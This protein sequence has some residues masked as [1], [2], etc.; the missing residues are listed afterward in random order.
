MSE[1]IGWILI[2][3]CVITIISIGI[4]FAPED[5]SEMPQ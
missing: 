5:N 1:T 4:I 2:I 3:I